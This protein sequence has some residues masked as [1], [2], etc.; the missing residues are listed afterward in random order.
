M[1][2]TQSI[3]FKLMLLI[4]V[5]LALVAFSFIAI[6]MLSSG[7]LMNDNSVVV[8]E[9]TEEMIKDIFEEWRVSTLSYAEIAADDPMSEMIDAINNKDTNAIVALAEKAFSHTGCD[10]MT[11]ADM[12]GNAIARVTSPSKFGD[13]IKSSL[14]IADALEGKSV[15]Y[16]YPT[17]NNGF[18]ITAGVP[19]KDRSGTQIGVIFLSRRLDKAERLARLKT[20][21]GGEIVLYQAN[22]PIMSTLEGAAAESLEELDE[23]TW[24]A[25]SAG[26]GVVKLV[27]M[28]GLDTVQ[29][30]V[31]I[32][33]KDDAVV[34]VL[35][36]INARESNRWVLL[37]WLCVFLFAALVM[38]PVVIFRIRGF[39]KPIRTL[40]EKAVQ[41]ASG[42]VTLDIV[43]NRKDEIGLLQ[44]SMGRLCEAMRAQADVLSHIAD[45]DLTMSYE[46]RSNADSVGNSLKKL[47]ERNNDALRGIAAAATQ[48]SAAST[49]IANGSQ[50]LAQGASEQATAVKNI[51]DSIAEMSGK[52]ERNAAMAR[53]AGSLSEQ[54][55]SMMQDSVRNMNDLVSAMNEISA[56]SE[57]VS[58]VIKVI[59]DITFQTNILALNAAVEAARA[60]IHGKGFAVVAEEVRN[61]AG[62][63]AEAA[64]RTTDIIGGNMTKVNLGAQIVEKANRSLTELSEN[65]QQIDE[66][67]TSIVASSNEQSNL[68]QEVEQSVLRVS[69]VVHANTANAAE[70]AARSEEMSGQAAI[71]SGLV[72][73]FSLIEG[74]TPRGRSGRPALGEQRMR[75]G[76]C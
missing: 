59:E 41:L 11:F 4:A 26:E 71:L 33:G 5:P 70:S 67:L 46:P 21:S 2:Y 66:I 9:S 61:L 68:I 50:D 76:G 38:I 6:A 45:G 42:D 40:S 49:Q 10:G 15:S 24:A 74:A 47:L 39:V 43:C 48:V 55:Q 54:S 72:G 31:P 30:Y 62:K 35:R 29:R 53:E 3:R 17:A 36:T 18:S 73:R 52:T 65:A 57:N 8:S 51:S 44:Q 75:L 16:A 37:L 27:R 28:D 60:G 19:V 56:A 34:G 22:V 32:R 58:K 14:A 23:E 64:G 12:E 1:R 69:D 63:S 25:L 20:M 7:K 13:N